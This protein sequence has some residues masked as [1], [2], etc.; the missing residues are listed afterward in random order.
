MSGLR[1]QLDAVRAQFGRLTPGYVVEAAR[2]DDAPLHHRFEWDDFE[3]AEKWR[4]EQAAELIRSYRITY[5]R[6]ESGS[7]TVRGFFAV[8]PTQATA[9]REYLPV[10]Q[11]LADPFMRSLVV[12]ELERDL[13]S[14]KA[15]YGHLK[16]YA[17]LIAKEAQVAA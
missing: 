7:K 16:E 12:R 5:A 9:E 8:R 10:Q 17:A 4:N 6:D 2:P 14:L 1:E 15:K 13:A 3:A 11:V